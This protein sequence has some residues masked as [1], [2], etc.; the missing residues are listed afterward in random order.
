MLDKSGRVGGSG[1]VGRIISD[2]S[3]GF[4]SGSG[5]GSLVLFAGCVGD[6]VVLDCVC[7]AVYLGLIRLAG[8]FFG[9]GLSVER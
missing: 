8:P 5:D 7:V 4:G 2:V 9:C 6:C 3:D 1:G